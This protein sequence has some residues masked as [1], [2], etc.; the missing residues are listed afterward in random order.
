MTTTLTGTGDVTQATRVEQARAVAEVA[1]SVMAAGDRARDEDLAL[2]RFMRS[3]AR[4]DFAQ[5]A[6]FRYPRGGKPVTGVTIAFAIEAA[7]C[8]GNMTSG[9]SEI[10]RHESEGS[11]TGY[12]TMVAFAWDLET[13]FTR[14][15][16]FVSPHSGYTDNPEADANGKIRPGRAL[17]AVRDVRE[18]NQSAGS[19]VER[20]QIIAALPVWFVE[21]GKARCAKAVA[22]QGGDK[23]IEQRR[24]EIIEAFEA[25][26]VRRADVIRKVGAPVDAWTEPDLATLLVIGQALKNGETTADQEFGRGSDTDRD[27]PATVDAAALAAGTRAAPPADTS[28]V[29]QAALNGIFAMLG[30]RGIAGRKPSER[31]R[32][33]RILA[34]LSGEQI[35]TSTDLTPEGAEAVKIALEPMSADDVANLL[36]A[37]EAEPGAME[38]Q[39]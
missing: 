6:F 25:R 16:T 18:N 20:E 37:D 28:K 14:R 15:T 9:S 34:L 35:A 30:E 24:R 10:E 1:A 23:P 39:P 2:A 27:T 21:A 36:A 4:L 26:G 8:W 32:R 17:V 22:E 5:R 12:S 7:R 29:A 11:R 19:R 13:N 38:P 33:L 3:C 31:T